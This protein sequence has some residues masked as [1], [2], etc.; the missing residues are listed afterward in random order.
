MQSDFSIRVFQL[1]V[2][3]HKLTLDMLRGVKAPSAIETYIESFYSQL[4]VT[5]TNTSWKLPQL[6]F[7][8]GRLSITP[9]VC[10]YKS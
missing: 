2:H 3:F 9:A 4:N 10:T 1:N 6:F 5:A 7:R 8:E